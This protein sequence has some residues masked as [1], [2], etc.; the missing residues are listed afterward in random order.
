MLGAGASVEKTY[1]F[2]SYDTHARVR[3]TIDV[4]ATGHWTSDARFTAHVDY[5]LVYTSDAVGERESSVPTALR[6]GSP[7][8]SSLALVVDH[9]SPLLHLVITTTINDRVGHQRTLD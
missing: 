8:S 7:H 2:A 1:V 3:V 4:I 9:S 6:T 5:T